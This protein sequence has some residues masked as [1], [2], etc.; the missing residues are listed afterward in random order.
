MNQNDRFYVTGAVTM[1]ELLAKLPEELL[2][3]MS[4]DDTVVKRFRKGDKFD[5]SDLRYTAE[6]DS[7]YSPTR[8]KVEREVTQ[9]INGGVPS[10][11]RLPLL[12][13]VM[14][15]VIEALGGASA[16]SV[17]LADDAPMPVVA[18]TLLAC[19]FVCQNVMQRK[20]NPDVGVQT[21]IDI[22][23]PWAGEDLVKILTGYIFI[24]ALFRQ[25][26]WAVWE[27][28]AELFLEKNNRKACLLGPE[29][30]AHLLTSLIGH[31]EALR[32]AEA[33]LA[34]ADKLGKKYCE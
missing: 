2:H 3:A 12:R 18:D 34:L 8:P 15:H 27:A 6:N 24:G 4:R 21:V 16:D 10:E 13:H 20:E 23:Q 32:Q 5:F 9:A 22:V 19:A 26:T 28:E 30:A 1:E 17:Y 7:W 11:E 14:T 25:K 33:E 31:A 29:L